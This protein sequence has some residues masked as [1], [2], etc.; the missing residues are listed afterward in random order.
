MTAKPAKMLYFEIV[1]WKIVE[2]FRADGLIISTQIGSTVYSMSAGG[3]IVIP[4]WRIYNN[5]YMPI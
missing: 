4:S 1:R 2:E 5:T 3:P